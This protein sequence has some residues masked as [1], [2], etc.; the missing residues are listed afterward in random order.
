MG[1]ATLEQTDPQLCSK[2]INLRYQGKTY[3]QIAEELDACPV[4]ACRVWKNY[5]RLPCYLGAHDWRVGTPGAVSV[6]RRDP[7]RWA[8][9]VADRTNGRTL[10]S[11]AAELNVSIQTVAKTMQDVQVVEGK[12][13]IK[14]PKPPEPDLVDAVWDM[15]SSGQTLA[16]VAKT[17]GVSLYKVRRAVYHLER[18]GKYPAQTIFRESGR[19]ESFDPDKAEQIRV[20]HEQGFSSRSIIR[21]LKTCHEVVIRVLE[22]AKAAEE[23]GDGDDCPPGL[24]PIDDGVVVRRVRGKLVVTGM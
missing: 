20:L 12:L 18:Q 13:R 9:L 10:A 24:D 2:I 5:K 6:K 14:L 7:E 1:R 17:L 21:Q 15:L 16:S 3:K 11:I 4:Q 23:Q 19:V 22:A 8:R